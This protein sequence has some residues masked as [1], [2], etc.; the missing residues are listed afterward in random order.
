MVLWT[1][2]DILDNE[3]GANFISKIAAIKSAFTSKTTRK[4]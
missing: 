4:R 1:L 3:Q 2:S